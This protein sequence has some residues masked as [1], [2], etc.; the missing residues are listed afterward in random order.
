MRGSKRTWKRRDRPAAK[1]QK[2]ND[3]LHGV[4]DVHGLLLVVL[5]SELFSDEGN[6]EIQ[7]AH[8][9]PELMVAVKELSEVTWSDLIVTNFLSSGF[10][11]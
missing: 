4:A 6:G 3:G 5:S 9:L 1:Q 11:A 2:S 7:I 10:S 8:P